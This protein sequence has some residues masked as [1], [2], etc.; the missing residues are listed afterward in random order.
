MSGCNTSTRTGKGSGKTSFTCNRNTCKGKTLKQVVVCYKECHRTSEGKLEDDWTHACAL[1]GR[2]GDIPKAIRIA[3][4]GHLC[5]LE[6]TAVCRRPYCKN[7][8][9][10]RRVNQ[11]LKDFS[12]KILKNREELKKVRNFEGIKAIVQKAADATPGIGRLAVYDTSIRFACALGKETMSAKYFPTRVITETGSGP[13]AGLDSFIKKTGFPKD[14]LLKTFDEAGL[15]PAEVE[16][17][18]CICKSAMD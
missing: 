18:L 14:D 4:T 12:E 16:N 3:A 1:A 15:V 9:Q 10:Q 2:S 13:G 5:G 17:M 6:T 8:H 7:V 11:T